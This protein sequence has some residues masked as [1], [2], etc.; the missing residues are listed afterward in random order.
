ML[1]H[2]VRPAGNASILRL[3]SHCRRTGNPDN[4]YAPN[5]DD[6]DDVNT[7]GFLPSVAGSKDDKVYVVRGLKLES[8]VP[9]KVSVGDL[10]SVGTSLSFAQVRKKT[11]HAR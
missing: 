3:R 8:I 7:H 11:L 10:G 9:K 4:A 1:S 5:G 2:Y 6:H